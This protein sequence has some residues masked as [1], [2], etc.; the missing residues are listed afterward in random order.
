MGFRTLALNQKANEVMDLLSAAKTQYEKFGVSLEKA[1]KKIDEAGKSLD[2]A[3]SRN[4]IIMKK[5]KGVEVIDSTEA[6]G[7]LELT[8]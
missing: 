6:S 4:S 1:K 3:Q 5:L 8:E 7:I 2:D